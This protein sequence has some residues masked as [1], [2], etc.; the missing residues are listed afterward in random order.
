MRPFLGPY[1]IPLHGGLLPP[2]SMQ[3]PIP[4]PNFRRNPTLHKGPDY[5]RIQILI[6][7]KVSVQ[8]RE[9]GDRVRRKVLQGLRPKGLG[10]V[11]GTAGILWKGGGGEPGS[12]GGCVRDRSRHKH[13]KTQKSF[14]PA[15]AQHHRIFLPPGEGHP[16]SRH[17]ARLQQ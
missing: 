16:F 3:F 4:F 7:L 10:Q 9:E 11:W 15:P 1:Y 6:P 2:P 14:F 17:R 13:P 12:Q 8:E 5:S